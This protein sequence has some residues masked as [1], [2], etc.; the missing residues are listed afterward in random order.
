MTQTP[1][2]AAEGALEAAERDRDQWRS[3]ARSRKDQKL[4]DT[5]IAYEAELAVARAAV[6]TFGDNLATVTAEREALHNVLDAFFFQREDD[7]GAWYLAALATG[8]TT[9]LGVRAQRR[10]DALAHQREDPQ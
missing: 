3:L 1:A 4:V 10:L 7:G 8:K 6:L 5:I 9:R 2:E